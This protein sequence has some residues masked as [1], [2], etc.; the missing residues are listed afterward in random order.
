[1]RI[2]YI[3]KAWGQTKDKDYTHK[4]QLKNELLGDTKS[5]RT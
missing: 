3:A 4:L 1:M 2:A 5:C